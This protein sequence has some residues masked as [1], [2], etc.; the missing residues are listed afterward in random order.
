MVYD[1][2]VSYKKTINLGKQFLK[3]TQNVLRLGMNEKV[4]WIFQVEK[5][6]RTQHVQVRGHS[7]KNSV[8]LTAIRALCNSQ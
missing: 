2:L 7:T 1:F 6:T 5:E 3:E 8:T 4:K